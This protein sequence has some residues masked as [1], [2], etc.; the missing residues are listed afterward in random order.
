MKWSEQIPTRMCVFRKYIYMY[1]GLLTDVVRLRSGDMALSSDNR[2]LIVSNLVDGIDIY[3]MPPRQPVR[4]YKH[5]IRV[6]KILQVSSA[7]GGALTVAGSDDGTVRLFEQRTGQLYD[8][9]SHGNGE[10]SVV[11]VG[12][13]RLISSI[14]NTMVQAV[15]VSLRLRQLYLTF[16]NKFLVILRRRTLSDCQRII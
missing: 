3:T 7:L 9:L 15:T 6:N 2:S 14:V 13:S 16:S 11:Q 1:Y 5:A 12:S 4:S 10:A 8:Q